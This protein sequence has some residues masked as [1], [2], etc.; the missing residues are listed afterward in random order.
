MSGS[1]RPTPDQIDTLKLQQIITGTEH[2]RIDVDRALADTRRAQQ[3]I[4]RPSSAPA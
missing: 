1:T 4:R 3:E 2:W